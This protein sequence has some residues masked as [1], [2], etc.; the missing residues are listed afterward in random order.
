M[1]NSNIIKYLTQSIIVFVDD[2]QSHK[3]L[4]DK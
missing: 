2:K 4:F 3:S 1:Y